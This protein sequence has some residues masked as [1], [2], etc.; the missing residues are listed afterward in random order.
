MKHL[1]CFVLALALV[2]GLSSS[3]RKRDMRTIV[4]QVPGMKGEVCK[5]IIVDALMRTPG[6]TPES[7]SADL[8]KRTVQVT[9]DSIFLAR[10]NIEF[11]IA[12]VGFKADDVP[13][14]EDA[15]AKLPAEC[16]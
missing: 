7:V 9:Y 4:V 8:E 5:R 11:A 16:R 2:V 15:A 12:D 6:V 14:K 1:I 13:A 10:K 3:C